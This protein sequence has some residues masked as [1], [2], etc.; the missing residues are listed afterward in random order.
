MELLIKIIMAVLAVGAVLAWRRSA[1]AKAVGPRR[2]F[3]AVAVTCGLLLSW[4]VV[5]IIL[6]GR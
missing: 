6:D 5:A 3:G 4:F 1:A 2:G